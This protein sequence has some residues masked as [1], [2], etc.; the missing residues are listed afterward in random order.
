MQA[1]KNADTRLFFGFYFAFVILGGILNIVFTQKDLYFWVNSHYSLF[2]DS[3]MQYFTYVGDG[4]TCIIVGILLLLFSKIR[5]GLVMLLAC[6]LEG[7]T[8]QVLKL[9]VFTDYP[10]PWAQY[11]STNVIHLVHD[12]TPY[13]NNSLPSGHTATAFCMFALLVLFW[14]KLKMGMLFFVLACTEA[15]S[16]IYLSQ[17]YFRDIY[18]GSFIGVAAA[19]LIYAYFYRSKN[20]PAQKYPWLDRPLI[21]FSK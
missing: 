6:G 12:F 20:Q 17:H 1:S 21:R 2:W 19:L 16:R 3:F 11:G 10:R 9:Y 7:L 5:H 4:V 8:V 13:T 15:Y 14:P 18:F